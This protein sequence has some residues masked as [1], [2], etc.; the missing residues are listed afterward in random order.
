[1]SATFL[2]KFLVHS[3]FKN[4]IDSL[5]DTIPIHFRI[6]SFR[7]IHYKEQITHTY[8]GAAREAAPAVLRFL[9]F[10]DPVELSDIEICV[11]A[12]LFSSGDSHSNTSLPS[13]SVTCLEKNPQ[14]YYIYFKLI[15]NKNT[16]YAYE[17]YI[18]NTALSN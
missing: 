15:H 13:I 12:I 2:Y 18:V 10:D 6:K 9:L 8:W 16:I 3:L 1:M 7:N 4:A 14:N 5:S 17:K 11:Y